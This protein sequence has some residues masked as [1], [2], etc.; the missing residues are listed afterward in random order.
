MIPNSL[1]ERN[2]IKDLMGILESDRIKLEIME[3]LYE[4]EEMTYGRMRTRIHTGFITIKNNCEF[5][6]KV[7]LITIE[8]KIVGDKDGK[9]HFV[10]LTDLGIKIQQDLAVSDEEIPYEK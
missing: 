5:L 10:K 6:E 2:H 1:F 3:L 4:N 9:M 8:K 7:K